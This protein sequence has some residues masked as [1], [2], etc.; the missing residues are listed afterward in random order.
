MARKQKSLTMIQ[1]E[2]MKK[3]Q[4]KGIEFRFTNECHNFCFDL[5]KIIYIKTKNFFEP[6]TTEIFDLLHEVGHIE[7]NIPGMC[8]CED[9]YYA[10]VWANKELKKLGLEITEKRKGEYQNHIYKNR[11]RDIKE[12]RRAIPTKKSM[13]IK[14]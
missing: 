12:K 10:T 4:K 5:Q 2:I 11:E 3:Y 1:L 14:W 7:T 9:E 6:T 8:H 13:L